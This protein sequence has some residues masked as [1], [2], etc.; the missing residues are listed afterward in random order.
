M[1]NAN[2]EIRYRTI[3]ANRRRIVENEVMLHSKNGVYGLGVVP[4]QMVA[5]RNEE[6]YTPLVRANICE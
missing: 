2:S 5:L 1:Q 4:V 3:K 6:V